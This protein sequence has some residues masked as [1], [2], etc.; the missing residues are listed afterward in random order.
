M[1]PLAGRGEHKITIEP[2]GTS[3]LAN[4]DFDR[5]RE[6]REVA[7][8][9]DILGGRGVAIAESHPLA[10]AALIE[11]TLQKVFEASQTERLTCVLELLTHAVAPV[12]AK[13]TASVPVSPGASERNALSN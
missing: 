5:I 6:R 9:D 10:N 3:R 2:I 12:F 11:G 7:G 4:G 13:N 8:S 1:E